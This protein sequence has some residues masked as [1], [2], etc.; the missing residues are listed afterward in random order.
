MRGRA[1]RATGKGKHP[2]AGA[3]PAHPG[4]FLRIRLWRSIGND[5]AITAREKP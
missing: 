1:A 5:P 3:P 2:G 4:V